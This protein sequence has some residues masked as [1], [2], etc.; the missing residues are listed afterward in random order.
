MMAMPF[1]NALFTMQQ[2]D[3]DYMETLQGGKA[4]K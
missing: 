3:D 1:K 4:R 2:A